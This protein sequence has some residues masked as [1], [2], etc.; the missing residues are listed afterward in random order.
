MRVKQF[1]KSA[2]HQHKDPQV[3][4]A[5]ARELDPADEEAAGVLAALATEDEDAGVRVA[6][7][8]RVDDLAV[9][10][11]LLDAN[12]DDADTVQ[13]AA[14]R[15]LG[16]LIE[17]G[18]MSDVAVRALLDTHAARIAP[19]VASAS[20]VPTQR[21][22]AL[23]ALD[24]EA[25]LVGVIQGS[26]LHDA[27]LAAANRLTR[28]DTMRAALAA[29]R[30]RDKVV[31]KLLQQRLDAEAAAEAARIAT[32][33]AVSTTLEGMKGL[34]DS[35]WS[36]QHPGRVQALRERWAGFD[37]SDTAADMDAFTEADARAQALLD[38]HPREANDT[39]GSANA[40]GT[41]G[42]TEGGSREGEPAEGSSDGSRT[43]GRRAASTRGRTPT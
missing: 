18:D 25:A 32:R 29:C 17:T 5:H 23:D 16:A 36:P 1:L 6:A 42:A 39:A 9:L 19:I 24:E 14:E 33:H 37:A 21:E 20:P 10:R 3:R 13:S 8:E 2:A 7:I 31:A 43:T 22:R 12:G 26:R 40:A 41:S 15:R 11:S 30:S 35:V 4:L 38:A 28:H 27:R 34:A